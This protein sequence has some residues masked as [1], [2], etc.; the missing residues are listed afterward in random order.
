MTTGLWNLR[1]FLNDA[2]YQGLCLIRCIGAWIF[3]KQKNL[4]FNCHFQWNNKK[5]RMDLGVLSNHRIP[6]Y[7]KSKMTSQLI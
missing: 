2:S 3:D 7:N 5:Q 1:Q 6:M 4:F